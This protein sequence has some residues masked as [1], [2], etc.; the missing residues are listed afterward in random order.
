MRARAPASRCWEKMIVSECARVRASAYSNESRK[1]STGVF[2]RRFILIRNEEG[3]RLGCLVVLP[4]GTT[5]READVHLGESSCSRS[6]LFLQGK[7][8]LGLCDIEQGADGQIELSAL[9]VC[10]G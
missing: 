3:N 4:E 1:S 2:K 7:T 8:K 10:H 9:R 6:S 5:E